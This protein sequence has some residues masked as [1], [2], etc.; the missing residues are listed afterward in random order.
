[1]KRLSLLGAT[2]LVASI[3]LTGCGMGGDSMDKSEEKK[4]STG[5]EARSSGLAPTWIPAEAKD[6]KVQQRTT[7]SE[8]LL[9]AEFQGKLPT[10]CTTIKAKG[11]PTEAELKAAYA[12]DTKTKGSPVADFT[13]SP[14]LSAGWWPQDQQ[15]ETT[16]LCGRWWVSIK[17]GHVYGFAAETKKAADMITKERNK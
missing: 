15:K 12:L 10:Q 14:L 13:T 6:V 5:S 4:A 7:G 3:S 2:A 17:D 9:T 11:A 8:R 16:A 1:M